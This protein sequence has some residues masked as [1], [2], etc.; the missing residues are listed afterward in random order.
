MVGTFYHLIS[1]S[2][3]CC[4]VHNQCIVF[5]MLSSSFSLPS[6]NK[7][8]HASE[9]AFICLFTLA[10]MQSVKL[11]MCFLSFCLDKVFRSNAVS[12]GEPRKLSIEI[13]AT[14][15]FNVMIPGWLLVGLVCGCF[16]MALTDVENLILW[17]SGWVQNS[18]LINEI[19]MPQR[20]YMA[21]CYGSSIFNDRGRRGNFVN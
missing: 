6:Q 8:R 5:H 9:N 16:I 4:V 3:Y 21:K 12:L 10:R 14:V 18:W 15:L 13:D 7:L 2:G 19:G 17:R 1:C 11:W 20:I